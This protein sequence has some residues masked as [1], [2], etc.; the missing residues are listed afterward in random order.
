MAD[1]DYLFWVKARNA[2]GTSAFSAS[3]SIHS[4]SLPGTPGAPFRMSTTSQTQ[5]VVGWT[6]NS[7]SDFGGSSLTG[8]EV[9]W[10]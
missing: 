5:V 10:N 1:K 8:Y 3:I 7:A 2:V 6:Q 9:W 4:A